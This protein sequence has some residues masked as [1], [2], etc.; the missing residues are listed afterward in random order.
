MAGLTARFMSVLGG[1][2]AAAAYLGPVD[3]GLAVTGIGGAVSSRLSSNIF[4]RHFPHPYERDEYRRTGRFP[5]ATLHTDPRGAARKLVLP[6]TQ[7]ITTEQ[8]DPFSD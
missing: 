8:Y 1:L 2:Y 5:A 7:A 4:S 3:T 6:L